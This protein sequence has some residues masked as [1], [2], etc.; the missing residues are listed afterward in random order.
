MTIAG[1]PV[2]ALVIIACIVAPWLVQKW[3][4]VKARRVEVATT[5]LLA[6]ID[7]ALP[8]LLRQREAAAASKA[9]ESDQR[10]T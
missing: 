6:S 1:I 2:W 9:T 8:A 10:R 7:P 3:A 5:A 4:E